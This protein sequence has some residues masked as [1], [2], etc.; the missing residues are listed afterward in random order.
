MHPIAEGRAGGFGASAH[1]PVIRLARNADE[2]C[3]RGCADG[4]QRR[5]AWGS[6]DAISVV[7]DIS[8]WLPDQRDGEGLRGGVINRR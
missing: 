4:C 8:S 1:L 6:A 7:I 5:A 3:I 2:I